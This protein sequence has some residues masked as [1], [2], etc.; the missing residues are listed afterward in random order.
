MGKIAVLLA[1]DHAVV[2]EGLRALLA[3]EWLKC[4]FKTFQQPVVRSQNVSQR[5]VG[6]RPIQRS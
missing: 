3:L 4:V 1:D 6:T 2:R 5:L